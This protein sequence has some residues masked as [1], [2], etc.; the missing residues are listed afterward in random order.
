MPFIIAVEIVSKVRGYSANVMSLLFLLLC[1]TVPIR[2]GQRRGGKIR[3]PLGTG[4][5]HG[6]YVTLGFI[7]FSCA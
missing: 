5:E 3:I 4:N 2:K 1:A 7:I 6:V